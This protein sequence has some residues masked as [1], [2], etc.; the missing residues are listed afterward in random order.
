MPRNIKPVSALQ[1]VVEAQNGLRRS[2]RNINIATNRTQA[3]SSIEPESQADGEG[4]LFFFRNSGHYGCF[5]QWYASA[6]SVSYNHFA[7]LVDNKSETLEKI[8]KLGETISL[9]TA[10]QYMMLGKAIVFGDYS[11]AAD[12]LDTDDPRAQKALGRVVENFDEEKWKSVRC[13][14]VERA[15]VEKFRQNEIAK[16]VLF[17]TGDR[18]LVEAAPRDKIWGI[19]LGAEKAKVTPKHKWGLNLL[20]KALVVAREELRAEEAKS[21]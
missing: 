8:K 2:Q 13:S 3:A 16:D 6:F 15:N 7:Y 11:T 9:S 17:G 5:S 20:G 12:I 1:A 18:E 14:I 4:P 10:E 21:G 19:G